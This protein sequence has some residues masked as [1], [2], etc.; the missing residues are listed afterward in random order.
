MIK[1]AITI[2][3]LFFLVISVEGRSRIQNGLSRTPMRTRN[4]RICG[5]VN[6][7]KEAELYV[8][9]IGGEGLQ[10][11]SFTDGAG[12]GHGLPLTVSVGK[13]Q[14]EN[15]CHD[16]NNFSYPRCKDVYLWYF[17]CGLETAVNFTINVTVAYKRQEN[18]TLSFNLNNASTAEWNPENLTREQYEKGPTEGKNCNFTVPL[19]ISGQFYYQVENARGDMPESNTVGVGYLQNRTAGLLTHNHTALTYNVSGVYKHQAVCPK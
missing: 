7:T 15:G 16:T 19:I 10:K 4:A 5:K 17:Y 6:L 9:R 11:L 3:M 1:Q 14:Y 2:G 18:R 13:M 12:T 8:K